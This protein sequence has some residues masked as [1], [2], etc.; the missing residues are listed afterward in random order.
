MCNY[1]I[2]NTGKFTLIDDA[3]VPG[4]LVNNIDTAISNEEGG[5]LT[6]G[7]NETPTDVKLTI[8]SVVGTRYGIYTDNDSTFNYYDGVAQEELLYKVMLMILLIYIMQM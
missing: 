5:T 3:N 7:V 4:S 8:P 2:K 6:L 1:T